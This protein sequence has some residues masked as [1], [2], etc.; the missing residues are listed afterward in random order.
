MHFSNTY[1]QSLFED[2]ILSVARS[3]P[4]SQVRT[5]AMLLLLIAGT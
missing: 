1:Y 2:S 5:A 4:N 3:T